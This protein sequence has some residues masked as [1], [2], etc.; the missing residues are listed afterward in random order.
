M[1]S[2]IKTSLLIS[3]NNWR[4]IF[5]S[6]NQPST[7][8]EEMKIEPCFSTIGLGKKTKPDTFL[9][10]QDLALKTF[11]ILLIRN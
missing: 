1:N 9:L 10:G 8:P 3:L 4:K 6:L 11:I 2:E 5:Q 7:N